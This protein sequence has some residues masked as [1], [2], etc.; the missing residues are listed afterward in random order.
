MVTFFDADTPRSESRP[1][2]ASREIVYQ[3]QPKVERPSS[4]HTTSRSLP[5]CQTPS[6]MNQ[7]SLA[8]SLC[9]K[10]DAGGKKSADKR[11]KPSFGF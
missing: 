8:K 11:L 7:Y 1:N 5:V 9:S 4:S 3:A 2:T 10:V 6:F